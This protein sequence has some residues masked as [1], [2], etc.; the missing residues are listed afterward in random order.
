MP[1]YYT[2][3]HITLAIGVIAI[4][5]MFY[6][7]SM[8]DG[9]FFHAGIYS[10]LIFNP[11][12]DIHQRLGPLGKLLG[13]EAYKILIPHRFGL[14]REHWEPVK[15]EGNRKWYKLS[16]RI[17]PIWRVFLFSHI[18]FLGTLPRC[19]LL[20]AP[21]VVTLLLVDSIEALKGSWLLWLWLGMSYSDIFH[22]LA[23]IITS[24]FKKMAKGYWVEEANRPR[25]VYR[26]DKK[27]YGKKR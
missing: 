13:L 25:M 18:P 19:I 9:L 26:G 8:V 4:P 12:L 7:P 5:V 27:G 24:D 14:K 11:D 20:V 2:H 10:T 3:K 23:D 15:S 21:F 17:T 22:T 16:E 6:T 1:N